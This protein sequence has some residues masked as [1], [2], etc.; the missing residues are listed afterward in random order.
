MASTTPTSTPSGESTPIS[1]PSRRRTLPKPVLAPGADQR[2]RDDREQ[3][4]RLG[5]HLRLVEKDRQRRD[6]EDAAADAEHAA[7]GA[8]G[9]PEDRCEHVVHQPTSSSIATTISSSANSSEIARSEIRCWSAVP[10]TTPPIA[11]IAISAPS[12]TSTLP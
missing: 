10:A 4:G 5:A 2:D 6:E 8:A 7:D 11:G 1:R 3:R 12:G 9:E